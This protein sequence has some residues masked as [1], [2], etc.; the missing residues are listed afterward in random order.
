MSNI[1]AERGVVVTG[2]S[3]GIGRACALRL[4]RLGFRVF[5][6][7]RRA[8]DGEVLSSAASQRL[9]PVT[10]DIT[11]AAAISSAVECVERE[12][13]DAGL[14]GLVNNAGIVV[15]GPLEY[16]PIEELR[17][18]LEVNVIGQVAV[19]Q[20]FVPLLRKAGGRIVNIGSISG[21]LAL[22]LLGPYCASKFALE[23][24]TAAFR[25]ELASSGIAVSLV[26]P[27][28][29]ATPIWRKGLSRGDDLAALLPAELHERYGSIIAR[30]RK[31]AT[32]SDLT[33]LSPDVVARSV[34]HA[35]TAHRPRRRYI[36]GRS[37]RLGEVGRLMPE[38]LREW[39]ILRLMARQR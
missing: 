20:A 17:R 2:A 8:E 22:P 10:M 34:A 37:A 16:L 19:T 35:L 27:G 36:M 28:G 30:Q 33:G 4:D 24:I 7:V 25:M 31:R 5:P 6:G 1:G 12:V 11:D 32:H 38:G 14:W 9:V 26:E 3:S 13:G 23:A 15:A 39:L 29:I 21:R 18:Q